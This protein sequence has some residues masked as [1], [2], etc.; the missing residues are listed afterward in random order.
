MWLTQTDVHKSNI[1]RKIMP[2]P[3][4]MTGQNL[5]SLV[6]A[7]GHNANSLGWRG[8]LLLQNFNWLSPRVK[9]MGAIC[10]AGVQSSLLVLVGDNWPKSFGI[11]N[12]S[13][14][15]V[16]S[17]YWKVH[18]FHLFFKECAFLTSMQLEN[19]FI[20]CVSEYAVGCWFFFLS[21]G[22]RKKLSP[23]WVAYNPTRP[24]HCQTQL[25]VRIL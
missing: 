12:N 6:L 15:F 24:K 16:S 14:T 22:K 19:N 13:N 18:S 10:T 17:F 3:I 25:E 11:V 20:V 4:Y 2:Y 9:K 7:C 23:F 5:N 21:Q 1:S 8:L